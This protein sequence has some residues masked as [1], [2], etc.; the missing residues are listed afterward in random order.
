MRVLG[1]TN[2]LLKRA[3]A[4]G[5][6]AAPLTGGTSLALCSPGTFHGHNLFIRDIALNVREGRGAEI[7]G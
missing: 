1:F 3:V 4:T 7:K 6:A 5:V 2:D